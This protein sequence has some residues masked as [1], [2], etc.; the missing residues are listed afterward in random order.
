M[1]YIAAII[2]YFT[3]KSDISRSRTGTACYTGKQQ[4]YNFRKLFHEIV[5][6]Y[7]YNTQRNKSEI[8]VKYK[9]KN[10]TNDYLCAIFYFKMYININH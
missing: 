9:R 1:G 2:G 5:F 6:M 8:V 4:P 7:L 10:G 3:A